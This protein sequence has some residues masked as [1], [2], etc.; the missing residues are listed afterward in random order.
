MSV[1]TCSLSRSARMLIWLPWPRS[2]R[3]LA[4]R[5]NSPRI[6]QAVRGGTP[7]ARHHRRRRGTTGTF[8][9]AALQ[10]AG[11]EAG[12]AG[13]RALMRLVKALYEARAG[14]RVSEGTVSIQ[15]EE[16]R[17]ED[18][19][20]AGPS[21]LG[22]PAAMG[23]REPGRSPVGD[24]DV[25]QRDA[26]LDRC[27]GAQAPVRLPRLPGRSHAGSH[28]PPDR[29]PYR[30]ARLLQSPRLS[31]RLRRPASLGLNWKGRDRQRMPTAAVPRRRWGILCGS[32]QGK[33]EVSRR[34]GASS[35]PSGGRVWL[36]NPGADLPC[37]LPAT[38]LVVHADEQGADLPAAGALV[39][40]PAADD[41]VLAAHV[42]D[43]PA[44]RGTGCPG[45]SGSPA[46]SLP[47]LQAVPA[48]CGRHP[49]PG[50]S[51]S[52]QL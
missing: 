21:R 5:P 49:R 42:L 47:P 38:G 48:G 6:R 18:F 13:W 46:A 1:L 25:G 7:L 9:K 30:A 12:R 23:Y 4:S 36:V 2:S 24:L 14:S 40:F 17:V 27:A 39:G 19:P 43:L 35:W 45:G 34:S 29:V 31:G 51:G 32:G 11:D 8:L 33:W 10:G 44:R 37:V 3:T 52:E 26:G 16:P 28:T 22:I 20:S 15:A 50:G 41:H